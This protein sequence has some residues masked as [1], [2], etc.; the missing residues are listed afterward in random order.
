MY[1]QTDRLNL[2]FTELSLSYFII[3]MRIRDKLYIS[4]LHCQLS[5]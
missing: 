1:F 2:Q 3:N 4:Y 5:L